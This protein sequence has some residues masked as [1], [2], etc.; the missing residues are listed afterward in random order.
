VEA[1][2][3]TVGDPPEFL[4]IDVEQVAGVGAFV[5]DP[6]V[7]TPNLGAGDRVDRRQARY[8][9]AVKDP[10]DGGGDQT[11]FAGQVHRSTPLLLAQGQDMRLHRRVGAGR[12][13][14][15]TRGTILQSGVPF[16][17]V[18]ADPRSSWA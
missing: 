12:D 15:R 8:V 4:H 11:E 9:V 16:G 3:A 2:A 13:G 5:A 17:A 10:P 6:G 7:A 14:A 1:P 18:A